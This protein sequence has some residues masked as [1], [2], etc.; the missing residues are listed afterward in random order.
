MPRE[1][2]PELVEY[3]GWSQHDTQQ[4]T[5]SRMKDFE[6]T[7]VILTHIVMLR[8]CDGPPKTHQPCAN[9]FVHS[10]AVFSCA[11]LSSNSCLAILPTRG[12]AGLGSVSSEHTERS[13]CSCTGTSASP[14]G[15]WTAVRGSHPI[16]TDVHLLCD[17]TLSRAGP[18]SREYCQFSIAAEVLHKAWLSPDDGFTE[19]LSKMMRCGKLELGGKWAPLVRAAR[20]THL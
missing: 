14:V 9:R 8:P 2:A 13:T 20:D 3:A 16:I 17:S 4:A 18:H 5:D 1:I 19:V 12:S 15:D 6:S 7:G 10:A 11:G